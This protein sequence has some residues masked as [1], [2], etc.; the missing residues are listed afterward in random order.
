MSRSGRR[1][2]LTWGNL[3][4]RSPT[5]PA[6]LRAWGQNETGL[7]TDNEQL[8]P[9]DLSQPK[10]VAA[11]CNIITQVEAP[12][13]GSRSQSGKGVWCN[14]LCHTL[15]LERDPQTPLPPP[16]PCSPAEIANQQHNQSTWQPG[17]SFLNLVVFHTTKLLYKSHE[18]HEIT[19]RCTRYA[20]WYFFR[21]FVNYTWFWMHYIF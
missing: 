11:P 19:Y 21:I 7:W 20:S 5:L 1:A 8:N 6:S 18:M 17:R 4:W 13:Q 15:V 9:S 14:W 10:W 2:A 12:F 3:G 16:S